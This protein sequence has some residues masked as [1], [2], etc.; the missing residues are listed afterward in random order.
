MVMHTHTTGWETQ[1]LFL[2]TKCKPLNRPGKRKEDENKM[3]F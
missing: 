1:R 2:I 3:V